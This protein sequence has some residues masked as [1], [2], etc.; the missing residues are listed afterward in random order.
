MGRRR[1]AQSAWRARSCSRPKCIF[2]V[3]AWNFDTVAYAADG[4]VVDWNNGNWGDFVGM[5]TTCEY[6]AVSVPIKP[7]VYLGATAAAATTT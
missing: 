1:H 3:W 6:R 7:T 2:V 4:A 5:K